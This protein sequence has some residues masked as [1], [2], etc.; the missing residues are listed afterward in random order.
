MKIRLNF[1]G[2]TASSSRDLLII[3]T[4][5]LHSDTP[6]SVAH[7]RTSDQHDTEPST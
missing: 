4:L 1:H 5:E 6:H 3:E 7:L 2:A